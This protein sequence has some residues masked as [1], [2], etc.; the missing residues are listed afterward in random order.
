MSR[1]AAL[2]QTTLND[3]DHL[4][5]KALHLTVG[6]IAAFT[7]LVTFGESGWLWVAPEVLLALAAVS[8]R[9]RVRGTR[10]LCIGQ[11]R[12]TEISRWS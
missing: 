3:T 2:L 8:G 4:D 6:D 10:T 7:I 11:E 1:A 5:T 9:N 12:A